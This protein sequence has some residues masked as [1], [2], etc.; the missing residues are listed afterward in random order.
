MPCR[1]LAC[2]NYGRSPNDALLVTYVERTCWGGRGMCGYVVVER[3]ATDG[4]TAKSVSSDDKR[5]LDTHV[6][7]K[8][9]TKSAR[10]GPLS[11]QLAHVHARGAPISR[12]RSDVNKVRQ[13]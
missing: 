4:G 6:T 5:Y 7:D 3:A 1:C 10:V 11:E 13:A 2:G 9:G 8:N 12:F